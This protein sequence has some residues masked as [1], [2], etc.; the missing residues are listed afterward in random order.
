MND[1]NLHPQIP[2]ANLELISDGDDNLKANEYYW[3]LGLVHL[4]QGRD[5]EAEICWST[6]CED[7]ESEAEIITITADLFDYLDRANQQKY[8]ESDWLAAQIISDC[9]RELDHYHVPTI[10]RAIVTSSELGYLSYDLLSEW[11]VLEALE[12]ANSVDLNLDLQLLERVLYRILESGDADS[13]HTIIKIVDFSEQFKQ[14]LISSIVSYCPIAW[15][16][17]QG[18]REF[19]IRILIALEP[20]ANSKISIL[21]NISQYSSNLG[22]HQQAIDA[23]YHFYDRCIDLNLDLSYQIFSNFYILRALLTAGKWD[24]AREAI[25]H[26][27][28]LFALVSE[29]TED[30][31]LAQMMLPVQSTMTLPYLSDRARENRILHNEI[32]QFCTDRVSLAPIQ[33]E[34]IELE[35]PAGILR[36]GYIAMSFN[37]HSVGSLCKWLWKYHNHDKFQIFTYAIGQDPKNLIYQKFFEAESDVSYCLDSDPSQ[38]AAQIKADEIDIL[39][40]LDSVT[41]DLTCQ[42]MAA[43]PA[44]VQVTWL[45]WDAS[46]IPTIDYYIADDLVLPANAEEYYQEKIWRMPGSYLAVDGFDVGI[47]TLKRADL[48][49]PDNAVIYWSGQAGFKRH[50]DT[51]RLQLEIIKRVP[52]SFLLI[53]GRTDRQIIADLFG[54]IATEV[55]VD[56]ARLRFIDESILPETYR[57]NLGMAD[58]V[59]DTFPYNGATTTLETLWM[60]VP[61]VTKVGEQFSARNSYTFMKHAGLDEGIA[62]TDEE[63]INWGVKLGLDPDLRAQIK[64]KLRSARHTSDLWNGEKFTRQME[65]AYSQMWERYLEKN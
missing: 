59:L 1:A 31:R 41:L 2:D 42:V 45:G 3:Q 9:L 65:V 19:I 24:E 29:Q 26:Q 63:Y 33:V 52:N 54:S 58:V 60:G 23:A 7:A 34:P 51:I 14:D 64:D 48:N 16:A 55:G 27:K 49:I 18:N 43:K 47:P 57:A 4:L 36:I 20:L 44:P 46:G 21:Q 15:N 50:P 61:I 6:P 22:W 35:K 28:E 56:L 37:D 12:R 53:K 13:I 62:W 25:E 10:L 39:I 40:D 30:L 5:L 38:I 32:A 11:Q 17:L 8:A